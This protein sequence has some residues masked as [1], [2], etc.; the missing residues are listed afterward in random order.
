MKEVR[1]Q[2]GV[3]QYGICGEQ[4][5]LRIILIYLTNFR[6]VNAASRRRALG[7]TNR[8]VKTSEFNSDFTAELVRHMAKR[9][10]KKLTQV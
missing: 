1:S 4:I 8:Y 3:N 6:S 10:A 7:H 5:F 9:R 2:P